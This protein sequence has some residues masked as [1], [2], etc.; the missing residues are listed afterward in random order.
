MV[1]AKLFNLYIFDTKSVY[2][3]GDNYFTD[4]NSYY[5]KYICFFAGAC[6]SSET[7]DELEEKKRKQKKTKN[8]PKQS[9]T[10]FVFTTFKFYQIFDQ[11]STSIYLFS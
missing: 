4:M 9:I 11:T 2:K 8:I 7:E 3:L 5:S 1:V 6:E 10:L